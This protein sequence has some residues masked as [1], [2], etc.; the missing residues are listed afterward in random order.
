MSTAKATV[1]VASCKAQQRQ[2]VAGFTAA[3]LLAW[4]CEM[5]G[6]RNCPCCDAIHLN[7]REDLLCDTCA[8]MGCRDDGGGP[9]CR[10]CIIDGAAGIYVP[11][12]FADG[13][14]F[15]TDGWMCVNPNDLEILRAGP[16]HEFYWEAW[17][18]V[19]NAATFTDKQGVTWGLEQDGDLFC[20]VTGVPE[21]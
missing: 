8:F 15:G 1:T 14:K 3:T 16:D 5:S 2:G 11:K 21:A 6:Y 10:E 19:L 12:E 9:S 17:E 13:F 4:G 7:E 20:H 18:D